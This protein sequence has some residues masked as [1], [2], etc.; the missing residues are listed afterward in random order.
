MARVSADVTCVISVQA[1][2]PADQCSYSV[3]GPPAHL[4]V[5]VTGYQT[6]LVDYTPELDSCGNRLSQSMQINLARANAST[7]PSLTRLTGNSCG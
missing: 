2:A 5:T 1:C 7:S 6:V 3:P 4:I